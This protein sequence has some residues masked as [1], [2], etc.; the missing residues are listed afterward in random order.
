MKRDPT[1][2][3]TWLKRARS[4]L[5][6]AELGRQHPD[7]LFEDL[8]FDAEQAVEKALKSVCVQLG[9]EFRKTHSLVYLMDLIEGAGFSI[10]GII[11]EAD[12]LTRYAVAARYPGLEEEVSEE[13]YLRALELARRVVE[14]VDKVIKKGRPK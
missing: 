10:P 13:E 1:D 8:C 3:R 2:P 14:W 6:R 9:L 12:V 4:N 11:K 7:I 5:R